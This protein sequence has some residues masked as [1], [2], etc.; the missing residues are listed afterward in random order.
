MTDDTVNFAEKTD[1]SLSAVA[2]VGNAEACGQPRP[3]QGA[4]VVKTLEVTVMNESGDAVVDVDDDHADDDHADD[5][6]ASDASDANNAGDQHQKE[7][8]ELEEVDPSELLLQGKELLKLEEYDDA[9]ES[10]SDALSLKID[11]LNGNELHESLF[12]YY[13][14]YARALHT[15]LLAR[16]QG[17]LVA[18]ADQAELCEIAWEIL[19]MCRVMC[20]KQDNSRLFELSEVHIMLGD[21]C[22]E[23]SDYAAAI[24]EYDAGL[25]ARKML[26]PQE[27]D[28]SLIEVYLLKASTLKSLSDDLDQPRKCYHAALAVCRAVGDKELGDEIEHL[29]KD[30]DEIE[31]D[32]QN[33]VPVAPEELKKATILQEATDNV[34]GTRSTEMENAQVVTLQPRSKK[35]NA[36]EAAPASSSSFSSSSSSSLSSAPSLQTFSSRTTE[37]NDENVEAQAKRPRVEA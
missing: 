20:E 14:T 6:H 26:Y 13:M 22:V 15:T 4:S 7:D 9:I 32:V 1:E 37:E 30:L 23:A 21:I 31:I 24:A 29:L 28:R 36:P 2:K 18:S 10:F 16:S 17:Q 8:L 3:E 5:D 35:R 33:S 27:N 12:E 25:K 34:F 19:D 11:Q